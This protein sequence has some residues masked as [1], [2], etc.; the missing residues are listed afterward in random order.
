MLVS[1]SENGD[2]ESVMSGNRVTNLLDRFSLVLVPVLWSLVVILAPYPERF[3]RV[4]DTTWTNTGFWFKNVNVLSN[5]N[6]LGWKTSNSKDFID[7]FGAIVVTFEA[8]TGAVLTQRQWRDPTHLEQRV[9]I[10]ETLKTI[11]STAIAIVR[12]SPYI[13][14]RVSGNV[15]DGLSRLGMPS[16]QPDTE[17]L[18]II[19]SPT[20]PADSAV[21]MSGDRNRLVINPTTA[22]TIVQFCRSWLLTLAI[23]PL[24]WLGLA[25][26]TARKTADLSS[27]LRIQARP[28]LLTSTLLIVGRCLLPWSLTVL[29]GGSA[30]LL[31]EARIAYWLK[32]FSV[33]IALRVFTITRVGL[34]LVM[35]FGAAWYHPF[36]H[37]TN[38]RTFHR[39]LLVD[40]WA[41]WD[42]EYFISL[43][44]KGY[45]FDPQA[46]GLA[47]RYP[48]SLYRSNNPFFPLYP[49]TI[50]LLR[51]LVPLWNDFQAAAIAGILISNVSFLV[52]LILL[53]GYLVEETTTSIAERTV[54]Y[55]ALFPMS[56]FYSAVYSESLFLLSCVLVFWFSRR[57]NFYLAGVMGA[58]ATLTRLVGLTL[59]PVFVWEAYRAWSRV[60]GGSATDSW[61]GKPRSGSFFKSVVK[62]SVI[63]SLL[64]AGGL[65]IFC[66]HLWQ[67]T[68]DPFGF[69]TSQKIFGNLQDEQMARPWQ[70]IIDGYWVFKDGGFGDEYY[71]LVTALNFGVTAGFLLLT[72]PVWRRYGSGV[73]L[74]HLAC[75]LIPSIAMLRSLPRYCAVLFPA[76]VVM[77]TWGENKTID[78]LIRVG[79]TLFLGL[80]SILFATWRFIA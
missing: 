64:T 2:L 66:L 79:F 74:F 68:G 39:N 41:R 26:A 27:A 9:E 3:H 33:S 48:N 28:F 57:G 53:H 6:G 76:F 63:A 12:I 54:W 59:I 43:A 36:K 5:H 25:L 46:E 23:G 35:F 47:E 4:V 24:L 78:Q 50:R 8:Q 44:L 69:Y 18:T 58:L 49:L 34:V 52:A 11:P 72:I 45:D 42:S 32:A 29:L 70:A 55:L 38:W 22:G 15:R 10:A 77:A 13:L 16:A 75:L 51:P 62:P 65:A 40:S 19:G 61:K 14:S 17:N 21:V 30:F 20:L 80:C 56:F 1:G 37:P 73:G 31:Y 71:N 7:G 60:Q 67:T